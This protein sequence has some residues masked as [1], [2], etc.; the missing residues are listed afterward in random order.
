[1]L[2]VV[3]LTFGAAPGRAAVEALARFYAPLGEPRA[4]GGA[5]G[6]G[7]IAFAAAEAAR[8]AAAGDS[9]TWEGASFAP[10]RAVAGASFPVTLY[11][12]GDVVAT[13][14]VAAAWLATGVRPRVAF[15][16]IGEL[17]AF[18]FLLGE[19]TLIE[20]VRALPAGTVVE[21]GVERAPSLASRWTPGTDALGTL[22]GSL[23]ERLAGRAAPR[24]GLTAGLDS[25]VVAAVLAAEQIPAGAFTWS[26][27]AEDAAGAAAVAAR[28]GL[29]HSRCPPEWLGD[30]AGLA[31]LR[32][33]ARWSEG[34][35]RLTPFGKVTWPAPM[36]AFVT[37]GGGEI[38]RAFYY[39][40]EAA[41]YRDP[42]VERLV[43]TLAVPAGIA[44][45][46]RAELERLAESGLGGWRLLDVF[47]AE[48]R[49]AKWGRAMLPFA[50]AP[51]VAAF[52]VPAV[53]AALAALPD[54][55]RVSDGFHREALAA[56][57]FGDIAPPPP[58]AQRAG[59][60]RPLR[61]A[62]SRVRR[63]RAGASVPARWA[64]ADE[65][66]ARPLYREWLMDAIGRT[67]LAGERVAELREGV[68]AGHDAPVM[69]AL[70]ATA[71]V[72]LDEALRDLPA[73]V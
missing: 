62:A 17:L 21:D 51:T 19:D 73:K 11:R 41:A 28:A 18:E 64:Y 8:L 35:A 57:G 44:P 31:R 20:G 14:A 33:D 49:V 43:R 71:P 67:G 4:G 22:R 12:C 27:H 7:W 9:V 25:R 36:D 1:V 24:L 6:V 10:G 37:G 60:P 15:E 34:A 72:A 45:R 61:R 55:V 66:E 16:R 2:S 52:A 40:L 63:V 48:Q 50:S 39:R 65:L 69:A 3:Y 46:L 5:G 58:V 32:A 53:A 42:D 29:P 54:A 47:Y 56:L 13:H 23:R 68:G 70:L 38:G 59:V 30:A 26:H